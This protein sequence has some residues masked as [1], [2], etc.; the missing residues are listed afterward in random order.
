MPEHWHPGL[1][2]NLDR[3]PLKDL[4]IIWLGMC[5]ISVLQYWLSVS[6]AAGIDVIA[7][8]QSFVVFL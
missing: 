7:L 4:V 6:R 1:P 3:Y 8:Y 5:T 2:R